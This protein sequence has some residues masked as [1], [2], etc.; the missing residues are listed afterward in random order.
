[1]VYSPWGLK[2]SDTTEQLS[3]EAY[4]VI[5]PFYFYVFILSM[6]VFSSRD[7]IISCLDYLIASCVLPST[8]AFYKSG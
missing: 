7:T 5:S 8:L 6:S 1:M 3:M 4:C 2:E